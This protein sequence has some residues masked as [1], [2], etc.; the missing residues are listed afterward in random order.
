MEKEKLLILK[1]KGLLSASFI[2]STHVTYDL[3]HKETGLDSGPSQSLTILG[4]IFNLFFG[5][6]FFSIILYGI[7][8]DL[9]QSIANYVSSDS[10]WISSIPT[11][12]GRGISYF[13]FLKYIII[14]SI[15]IWFVV[16]IG[17]LFT[18]KITVKLDYMNC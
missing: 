8:V 5:V 3:F 9:P 12:I 2:E 6:P 15:I 1:T 4:R 14:L 18:K 7:G 10:E 13:T 17:S 11:S 16:T